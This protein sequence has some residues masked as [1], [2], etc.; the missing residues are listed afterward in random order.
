MIQAPTETSQNGSVSLSSCGL[1]LRSPPH[2]LSTYLPLAPMI[3]ARPPEI[4]A[5]M[6]AGPM[7]MLSAT[8]LAT[9]EATATSVNRVKRMPTLLRALRHSAAPIRLDANAIDVLGYVTDDNQN[10]RGPGEQVQCRC[11]RPT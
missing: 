3:A 6:L 7:K 4:P 10:R 5:V 9:T 1:P 11:H 2:P 8:W